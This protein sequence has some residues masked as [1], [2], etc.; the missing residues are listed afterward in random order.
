VLLVKSLIPA[1]EDAAH[2]LVNGMLDMFP[3]NCC[4]LIAVAATCHVIKERVIEN[5][6]LAV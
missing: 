4:K 6:S 2:D 3:A 1:Q 5:N